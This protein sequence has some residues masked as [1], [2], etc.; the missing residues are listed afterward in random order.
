MT[1]LARASSN[2][3]KPEPE[4]RA[5]KEERSRTGAVEHENIRKNSHYW[6]PLPS[7]EYVKIY[8]TGKNME[9]AVVI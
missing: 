9:S 8:Q 3:P 4:T 5:A 2:L 1:V 7:N 6:M